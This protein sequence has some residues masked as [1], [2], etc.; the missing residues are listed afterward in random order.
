MR[1]APARTWLIALAAAAGGLLLWVLDDVMQP[2]QGGW[3]HE[4]VEVV[5][6]LVFVPGLTVG[7]FAIAEALRR[8]S[9]RLAEERSR[10]QRE[11]L[12]ALGAV[13]AGVAHE[14][15]NPLHSIR[16]ILDEL[17][18]TGRLG[19]EHAQ[20]LRHVQ[21]IDRAVTL[22]YQLVG[23]DGG[24]P[25][26]DLATI[27]RAA[28]EE[29]GTGGRRVVLDLPAS[30]PVAAAGDALVLITANLLRNALTAA[31]PAHGE[32]R[33]ALVSDTGR[34]VLTISNPGILPPQLDPTVPRS[35][36]PTDGLGLGLFISHQLANA[37]NA[38][39]AIRQAGA[40]VEARLSVPTATGR[41]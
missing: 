27:V 4:V 6:F 16:L 14:V 25:V 24:T 32:V 3:L 38:T 41:P 15:R 20:L 22:A 2:L 12:L 9:E 34:T 1:T 21:R 26:A 7:S 8:R 13:A 10:A 33:A 28:A 19:D 30:A 29:E 18:A 23:P 40:L 31:G 39:L 17:H 35:V 11:R 36:A 5:E 37:A